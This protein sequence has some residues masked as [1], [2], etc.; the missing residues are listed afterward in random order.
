MLSSMRSIT[1]T[2]CDTGAAAGGPNWSNMV[3][4]DGQ[5]K[6]TMSYQAGHYCLSAASLVY[7]DVG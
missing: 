7:V 3:N 2:C 4:N 1:C 5:T 6:S